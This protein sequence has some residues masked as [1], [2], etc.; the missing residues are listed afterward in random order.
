MFIII[1]QHNN[2]NNTNKFLYRAFHNIRLNVLHIS[3]LVL[4][5]SQLPGE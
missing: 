3:A 5:L 1:L 2:N 4:N